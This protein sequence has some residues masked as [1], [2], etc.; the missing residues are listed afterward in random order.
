MASRQKIHR[1][2]GYIFWSAFGAILPLAID[3]FLVHPALAKQLSESAFGGLIWVLGLTTMAGATAGNGFAILLMRDISKLDEKKTVEAYSSSLFMTTW[4]APILLAITAIISIPFA[5]DVVKDNSL[6]IY[7]TLSIFAVFRSLETVLNVKFRIE[8]QFKTIFILRMIEA[9][10]LC[11]NVAFVKYQSFWIIGGIYLCSSAL[12]FIIKIRLSKSV[13]SVKAAIG[14]APTRKWLFWGWGAGA[15]ITFLDLSQV[16]LAR[17]LLGVFAEGEQVAYFYVGVAMANV[18]IMPVGVVANVALSL[19]GGRKDFALP[20]SLAMRYFLLV[21]CTAS[22]VGIA[23][24]FVGYWLVGVLYPKFAE[25]TWHFYHWIVI[26]VSCKTV[27][28]LL[29]PVALKYAALKHTV[30]LIAATLSL[31]VIALAL[32]APS[33]GASGAA[34]AL[35]LSGVASAIAWCIY[36]YYL[37]RRYKIVNTSM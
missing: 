25:S 14:S 23:A 32:L 10:T 33:Q 28:I 19:L 21:T 1:L 9:L 27:F 24:W 5:F 20:G 31:Q 7:L 35:A 17:T 26:S 3:R 16:Y 2:G 11:A 36:Y 13:I 22:L 15:L 18:F 37:V 29:R 6:S 30:A 34:K 8:R 4:L 12:P